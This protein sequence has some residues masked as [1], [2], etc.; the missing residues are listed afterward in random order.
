MSEDILKAGEALYSKQT[1]Y[2][3]ILKAFQM[4]GQFSSG[5]NGS[6][7]WVVSIVP[8]NFQAKNQFL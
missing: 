8:I 6:N 2:R 5:L 7:C 1:C 3:Q 4:T